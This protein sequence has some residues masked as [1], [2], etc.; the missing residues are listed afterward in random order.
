MLDRVGRLV[1]AAREDQ[2]AGAPLLHLM[3]QN[4]LQQKADYVTEGR[5]SGMYLFFFCFCGWPNL[6]IY[7]RRVYQ[8]HSRA[9]NV[10]ALA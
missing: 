9:L 1:T 2:S 10:V 5:L 4:L 7:I 3:T 8:K 6:Y